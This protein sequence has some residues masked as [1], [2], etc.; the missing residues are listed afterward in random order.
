MTDLKEYLAYFQQLANEHVDVKDFYIMDINEAMIALK[1]DM[2]FPAM[3]LN[4]LT[5]SF[6]APNMDNTLDRIRGGFFIID[7]LE[8][9]DDFAG[10]MQILENTKRIGTEIIARMLYDKNKCELRA[11]KAIPG[12]HPRSVKYEMLGHLFDSCFGFNF[13]F[14]LISCL[15]LAYDE[16]KWDNEKSIGKNSY[17]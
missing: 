15:D 12:F 5:G 11:V 1:S 6:D 3:V 4:S 7:Q 14:E 10:E 13:T 2:N 16:S 17:L 8:S 9:I